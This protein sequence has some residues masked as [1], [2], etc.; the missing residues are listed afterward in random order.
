MP[1][2]LLKRRSPHNH[3]ILSLS[4][5]LAATLSLSL[6]QPPSLSTCFASLATRR[7]L[8]QGVAAGEGADPETTCVK[9][10]DSRE[11]W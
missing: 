7:S 1:L 8:S 4:L 2:S 6:T 11:E 5:C 3:T 10:R 9:R